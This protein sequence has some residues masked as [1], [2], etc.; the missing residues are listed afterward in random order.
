MQIDFHIPEYPLRKYVK[1]IFCYRGYSGG[2]KYEMIIPDCAQQ[3]IIELDGNSRI[4][5]EF[6]LAERSFGKVRCSW[7]YGLFS[8]PLTYVSEKNATTMC[9][10]F[11][12][13]G[14]Y[15]FSGIPAMEF[16]NKV[17]ESELL[18][19][20]SIQLL[21]EQLLASTSFDQRVFLMEAYLN[22]FINKQNTEALPFDV[23][24]RYQ[25]F[26]RNTLKK[27]SED[28]GWSQR[29]FISLFHQYIG[30]TPKKLQNLQKINQ[31][32]GLLNESKSGDMTGIAAICGFFD[33]SHFI[34]N[35]KSVTG[36]TPREYRI[37]VKNYPNVLEFD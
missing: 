17:I 5:N 21:R 8:R 16:S 31:S 37:T 12:P 7:I 14:L 30:T 13:H 33:Q 10:Q 2:K 19:G 18:L 28:C 35:F 11:E 9:V 23:F 20:S 3:L 4:F 15:M 32:L 6:G 36:M 1:S 34:K 24:L 29:H 25:Y 26:G 27:I 22:S